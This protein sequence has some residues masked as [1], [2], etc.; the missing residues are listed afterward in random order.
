MQHLALGARSSLL[1][2][3]SF[4]ARCPRRRAQPCAASHKAG[5]SPQAAEGP[6]TRRGL[7]LAAGLLAASGAKQPLPALAEDS[8]P[9]SSRRVRT[10]QAP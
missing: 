9:S 1:L 10:R 8:A 2:G 5:D 7:L 6:T 3:P 4:T